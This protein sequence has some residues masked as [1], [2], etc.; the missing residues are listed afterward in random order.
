MACA[1][2]GSPRPLGAATLGRSSSPYPVAASRSALVLLMTLTVVL[3]TPSF[4]A[5]VQLIFGHTGALQVRSYPT[6]V[7]TP[8]AT[9]QA[10][11]VTSRTAPT[12]V[13]WPGVTLGHYQFSQMLLSAPQSWSDGPVVELRYHVPHDQQSG[14]GVLDIREF[15]PAPTLAH[16][17]QV[18]ADGSATP[19]TVGF[20]PAAYVDGQWGHYGWNQEGQF[21]IKS[22]VIFG[23]DGRGFW[24]VRAQRHCMG[25]GRLA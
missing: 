13:E 8:N 16:V 20:A 11:K 25:Q 18:V 14:S 9:A 22:A 19:V 15:R 10:A 7:G 21:G 24:H 17:L 23:E 6:H 12:R 5:G 4:A 1:Q 3:A 2:N